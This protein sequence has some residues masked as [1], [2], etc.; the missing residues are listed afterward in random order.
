MTQIKLGM[1]SQWYD[2]E[3]GSAVVAGVVARSLARRGMDVQVLTGFPNYPTGRTLPGYRQRMYYREELSGVTVHRVPLYPN[4]GSSSAG[5][6]ASYSSF[7]ASSSA[8]GIARLGKVDAY[9]VYSTP[10]TVGMGPTL[11]SYL[12]GAP[13]VTFIQD[14]WPETMLDSG[15]LAGEKP[16]VVSALASTVS[17]WLYRRSSAIAVIS[18]SMKSALMARGIPENRIHFVPN[19]LSEEVVPAEIGSELVSGAHTGSQGTEA[20]SGVTRNLFRIIY[21]GNLGEAQ[22]VDTILDA[23]VLLR[24]RH[25]IEFVIVGSGVLEERM[26]IRVRVEGLTNVRM[27][28]RRSNEEIPQLVRDSDAQI[29]SLAPRPL[30]A[31]TIP[32][33][34]QFSLALGRPILA[35]VSGD[36][37]RIAHESGASIIVE[38]GSAEELAA[39]IEKLIK[40]GPGAR[41]GMGQAGLD[42]FA[43]RFSESVGV[44]RLASVIETAANVRGERRR[45]R[46]A[47]K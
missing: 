7:A 18:P 28:G 44:E 19:W 2:P 36:A 45:I 23:A 42:Y 15:F 46:R 17:D 1:I 25:P 32:S 24:G 22:S 35:A 37:A 16:G 26:R 13:I 14:L 30:F 40:L 27:L 33:K 6:I 29:V 8:L 3:G 43:A 20:D 31:M 21:A 34:L 39:G 12:R 47:R 9:L 11:L 41:A 4:H 10:V 5:R 38:P